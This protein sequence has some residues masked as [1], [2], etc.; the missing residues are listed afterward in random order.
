[1]IEPPQHSWQ[2]EEQVRQT[3][4]SSYD[5]AGPSIA[6]SRVCYL[7]GSVLR[8]FDPLTIISSPHSRCLL[9]Q[10]FPAHPP[11]VPL[12]ANQY[13][14]GLFLFVTCAPCRV[15]PIGWERLGTS[16]SIMLVGCSQPG[17]LAPERTPAVETVSNIA[18]YEPLCTYPL[19]VHL[20][21]GRVTSPPWTEL[22]GAWAKL[23]LVVRFQ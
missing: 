22:M 7:S 21:Q 15:R 14:Q 19:V 20:R 8:G 3:G 4:T 17:H 2:R 16:I 6:L 23:R 11:H 12:R 9:V 5:L 18:L 10:R 1:M 13:A